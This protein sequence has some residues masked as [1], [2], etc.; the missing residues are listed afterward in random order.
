M[1]KDGTAGKGRALLRHL[2]V[3]LVFVLAAAL[4]FTP[5]WVLGGRYAVSA[6]HDVQTKLPRADSDL[7]LTE[8]YD[9]QPNTFGIVEGAT[10]TGG[11]HFGRLE[12]SQI[13]LDCPVYY[14]ANR[15]CLRAGAAA[16][17]AYGLPGYGKST[18]V[19][20]YNT[21]VFRNLAQLKKRRSHRLFYQLG[22]L[23]LPGDGPPGAYLGRIGRCVCGGQGE[24]DPFF[25]PIPSRPLATWRISGCMC[26]VKRPPA[27]L[28]R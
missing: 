4:V 16:S 28:W 14:G 21:T 17:T 8:Q 1:K 5:I 15:V 25:V 9:P 12:C 19:T 23:L 2:A 6:V 13:G 10:V 20:G 18:V 7:Q 11:M 24:A 26:F 27:R 22:A 3:V